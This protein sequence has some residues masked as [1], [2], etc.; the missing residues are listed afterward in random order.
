MRQENRNPLSLSA[1]YDRSIYLTEYNKFINCEVTILSVIPY[2][3]IIKKT[4]TCRKKEFSIDPR[5]T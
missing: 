3:R 2:F 5:D 4:L 1:S